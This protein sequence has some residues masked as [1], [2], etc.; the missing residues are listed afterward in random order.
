MFLYQYILLEV[1]DCVTSV[2]N[3]LRINHN[4]V[5]MVF[6]C[7]PFKKVDSAVIH[8]KQPQYQSSSSEVVLVHDITCVND[9]IKIIIFNA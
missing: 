6:L 3:M 4:T 7:S 5:V 9:Y 2:T 8:C 1:F